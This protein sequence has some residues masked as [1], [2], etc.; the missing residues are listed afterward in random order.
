MRTLISFVAVLFA[1]SPVDGAAP[2]PERV[3]ATAIPSATA[4]RVDGDLNDA[5]WQTAPAITGFRQRDPREGAAP[6]YETEARVLY[7]AT[8]LYV[9]VQAFDP[10]PKRIVGIRTRRDEGSP[11]DWVSVLID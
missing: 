1:V 6:T 8:A 4:V 9:A 2:P 11:S 10:E 3:A 5:V 7:D